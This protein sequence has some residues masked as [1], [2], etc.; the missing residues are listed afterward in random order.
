MKEVAEHID[1]LNQLAKVNTNDMN[2]VSNF[3]WN[4]WNFAK[5]LKRYKEIN[6]LFT[7]WRN[8]N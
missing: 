2:L 7:S 3:K 5:L 4:S 6:K 8:T 1:L